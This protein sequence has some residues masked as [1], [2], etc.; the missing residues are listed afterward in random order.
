MLFENV[1][2]QSVGFDQCVMHIALVHTD[3]QVSA[4]PCG[5]RE[6]FMELCDGNHLLF[7]VWHA[8]AFSASGLW[9]KT[10][11]PMDLAEVSYM[12]LQASLR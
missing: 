11:L 10:V 8:A 2:G 3:R 9:K 4:H 1:G 5:E 7:A 6:Q 12:A